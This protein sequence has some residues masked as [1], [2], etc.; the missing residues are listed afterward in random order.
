MKKCKYCKSEIDEQAKICPNCRKKQKSS[1]GRIILGIIIA[2]LGIGVLANISGNNEN[3]DNK[4]YITLEKFN[5]IENGMTYDQVKDII[6]CDGTV[7]SETEVSNIKMTIY[8]WYG[9]DNISNANVT[10]QN[11]K[12]ISKAQIGLK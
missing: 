9:K 1:A 4:C 11:G 3:Q 12:I 10:V 2:F 5:K 7:N 8:S 6:G